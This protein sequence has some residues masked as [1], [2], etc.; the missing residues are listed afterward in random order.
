MNNSLFLRSSYSLV[1]SFLL[2]LLFFYGIC[3]LC[4]S[5]F[6]ESPFIVSFRITI[7]IALIIIA[8]YAL[9]KFTHRDLYILKK[10]L[11]NYSENSSDD[12][13]K[14]LRAHY[15]YL[16]GASDFVAYDVSK[17]ATENECLAYGN[18][19]NAFAACLQMSSIW[20]VSE[21]D[22]ITRSNRK[23]PVSW[24]M[25]DNRPY[26]LPFPTPAVNTLTDGPIYFYPRFAVHYMSDVDYEVWYYDQ[27]EISTDNTSYME[28]A[29]L[30]SKDSEIIDK[31]WL[32]TTKNG[33]PDLRYSH[34]PQMLIL[35]YGV[36]KI[37]TPIGTGLLYQPI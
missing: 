27:I 13:A 8:V 30:A 20:Q 6:C 22:F 12:K 26:I 31:T 9:Y 35:K 19:C 17:N 28:E 10:E 32:F 24:C 34:N 21:S 1:F 5:L 29:S 36:V 37:K 16:K 15:L 23:Q 11:A 4:L 33:S 7:V 3:G 2:L 18:F 25:A 14:I